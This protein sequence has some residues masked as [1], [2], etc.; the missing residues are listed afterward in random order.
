[1]DKN[2]KREAD[3]YSRISIFWLAPALRR[4]E[5]DWKFPTF[6]IRGRINVRITLTTLTSGRYMVLE[7]D[8][9]Q[10]DGQ[11]QHLRYSIKLV[12]TPCRYGGIRYWFICPLAVDGKECGRRV[13]VLYKFGY[14]FGCRHCHNLTYHSRNVSGVF[15]KVG[16]IDMSLLPN[17]SRLSTVRYYK[18]K[19]TRRF[20]RAKKMYDRINLFV[21]TFND[22]QDKRL[23]WI[24]KRIENR[25][26]AN[27]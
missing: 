23:D 4:S 22:I 18:G 13:A 25:N 12:S 19:P 21:D 24:K 15:R 16:V 7:Y 9:P 10:E 1:M 2:K 11:V 20:K 26:K 8:Q 5:C 17:T 27:S 3:I 14:Y 6:P